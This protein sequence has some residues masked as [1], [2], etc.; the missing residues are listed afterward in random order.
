MDGWMDGM[1]AGWRGSVNYEITALKK[2]IAR[3][4]G[5]LKDLDRREAEYT[6]TASKYTQLFSA[7]CLGYGIPVACPSNRIQV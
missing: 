6:A 2:G 1:F 7:A 5:R 4:Q 3:V